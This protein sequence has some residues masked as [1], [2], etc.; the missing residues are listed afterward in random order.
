MPNNDG[1]AVPEAIK[2]DVLKDAL[3]EIE[4]RKKLVKEHYKEMHAATVAASPTARRRTSWGWT[5]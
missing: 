3:A 2:K 1:S 4:S 5:R